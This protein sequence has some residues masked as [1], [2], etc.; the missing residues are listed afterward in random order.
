MVLRRSSVSQILDDLVLQKRLLHLYETTV[1]SSDVR[2]RTKA[3][4][5]Q[6]AKEWRVATGWGISES[7]QAYACF[8]PGW[9][10]T[11]ERVIG[12]RNTSRQ[13]TEMYRAKG[14]IAMLY[15]LASTI[16]IQFQG[17]GRGSQTFTTYEVRMYALQMV[18]PKA[19]V[20]CWKQQ[21]SHGA[22]RLQRYY[23]DNTT[24]YQY[25]EYKD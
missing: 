1:H 24:R 5:R 23:Q 11:L 13:E 19:E 7:E 25:S 22:A 10:C 6:L 21:E 3:G 8:G 15:L 14:S 12:I 4:R 9:W 16:I 18:I 17:T 20:R 2:T